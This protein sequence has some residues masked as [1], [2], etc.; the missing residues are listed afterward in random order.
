M[1]YLPLLIFYIVCG[2][3][4]KTVYYQFHANNDAA[5]NECLLNAMDTFMEE[6]CVSF[7]PSTEN[8]VVFMKSGHCS[9]QESNS[10]VHMAT[11][12][13]NENTCYL[14]LSHVLSVEA[15][16]RHSHIPRLVNIKYNCTDRCTLECENGG[17][18]TNSCECDCGYGFTGDRCQTL[19]KEHHFSDSSCGRVNSTN[20]AL[21][22]YPRP[23]K[24]PVFCQWHIKGAPSE[25][26]EFYIQ[27][28]DLDA[29]KVLPSQPCND[30]LYIWGSTQLSNPIACD[31]ESVQSII[32]K[33]YKSDS[34]WLLVE[35][36]MNPWSE[37]AHKGPLIKY[38]FVSPSPHQ[39]FRAYSSEMSS[40]SSV[41]T[42][43]TLFLFAILCYVLY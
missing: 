8:A 33:K 10:T 43:S 31:M 3:A 28:L 17:V 7:E 5:M 38:E 1:A 18:V 35:L 13:T 42:A 23:T 16:A 9:W 11:E 29:E 15:P 32:G 12:C 37:L 2:A 34:N 14:I 26:I 19:L 25:Y 4:S 27:D 6:T 22:A 41:H 40:S 24:G 39:V 36:R 21:S 20:V 30:M